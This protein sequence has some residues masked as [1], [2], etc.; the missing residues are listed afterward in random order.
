M[1]LH[2]YLG[3]SLNLN[4]QNVT[5]NCITYDVTLRSIPNFTDSN[6]QHLDTTVHYKSLNSVLGNQ[7]MYRPSPLF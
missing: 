1:P 3:C 6:L 2:K 4:V 7:F 5:D